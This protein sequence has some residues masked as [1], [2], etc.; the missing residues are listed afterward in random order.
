M[1]S[2]QVELPALF[3]AA[4]EA[5]KAAQTKHLRLVAAELWL[6]VAAALLL[7][8]DLTAMGLPR[9]SQ[10]LNAGLGMLCLGVSLVLTIVTLWAK[11]ETTWY[12]ARSVAESVKSLS[13]KYMTSVEPFGS[14]LSVA[15]ADAVFRSNLTE[16][17]SQHQVLLWAFD[18]TVGSGKQITAA[19]QA[20]RSADLEAKKQGY[21]QLRIQDQKDW[22]AARARQ[23]RDQSVKWLILVAASQLLAILAAAIL[24]AVPDKGVNLTGLFTSLAAA[25]VAWV[26]IKRHREL[27]HSYNIAAHEL[28]LIAERMPDVRT[29]HQLSD[30]VSDAESAISREHVL[31]SVRR[32]AAE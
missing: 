1:S 31:W 25:L 5:S 12:G 11:Y 17:V 26:Q 29:D 3:R 30:F 7:S 20:W 14:G 15:D 13:W 24:M 28:G 4:D 9:I 32:Q 16:I 2:V 27:A 19:M 6:L 22:Y 23:G 21:L 18:G 8:F 10:Q